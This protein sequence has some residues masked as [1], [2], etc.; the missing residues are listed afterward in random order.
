MCEVGIDISKHIPTSVDVYRGQNWNYV[1]T[2]CGDARETCPVFE[3]HVGK[4]L[5]LGFEDPSNAIGS[6]EHIRSE[7]R[8]VRDEIRAVFTRFHE[9]TVKE[10]SIEG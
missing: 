1:I 9:E 10:S 3:G 5:H 4:C 7:F 8:R 6:E 2:V